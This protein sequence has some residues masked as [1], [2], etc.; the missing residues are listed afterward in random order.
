MNVNNLELPCELPRAQSLLSD[1]FAY[2][3]AARKFRACRF[4]HS[5]LHAEMHSHVAERH[6][7]RQFSQGL[8]RLG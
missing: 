3:H 1:A 2:T 8:G 4:V 6:A 7:E 5:Q